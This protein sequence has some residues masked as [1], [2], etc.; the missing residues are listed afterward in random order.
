MNKRRGKL[1]RGILSNIY[2]E[3]IKA[4]ISN[5]HTHN[6]LRVNRSWEK[7]LFPFLIVVVVISII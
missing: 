1:R 2:K 7:K 4:K 6:F 3:S 5:I